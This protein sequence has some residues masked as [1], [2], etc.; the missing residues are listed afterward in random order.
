MS[1][2]GGKIILINS[3]IYKVSVI[4]PIYNAEKY[5]FD[6]LSSIANQEYHD[7][8][9]L[10][11]DDGSTDGSKE[12]ASIFLTNDRRFKYFHQQNRGVSA[13]RNYGI[14]NSSGE[15]IIFVDSDDICDSSYL[16]SLINAIDNQY[17]FVA[18]GYIYSEEKTKTFEHRI[19]SRVGE[20]SKKEC[21]NSI[22][23]DYSIYTFPWNK[24]YNK[25]IIN[26]FQIFFD[27]TITYGE[28]LLFN[29]NYSKNCHSFLFIES[30]GYTYQSHDGNVTGNFSDKGLESRLTFLT[31]IEKGEGLLTSRFQNEINLLRIKYNNVGLS[32]YRYM[33]KLNFT[34]DQKYI[35]KNKLRENYKY[36]YSK[37]TLKEKVKYLSCLL[38][39][40]VTS[41]ISDKYYSQK[42]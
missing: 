18:G 26:E 39:P 38:F 11:I 21:I 29:L 23:S 10:L 15:Y 1:Y 37:L 27:E 35:L 17:D 30:C 16:T 5:L 31:A 20:I 24:I 32:L 9:V 40:N 19:P 8:E 4:V 13:A 33:A 34:K 42:N 3:N 2:H 12:V 22:I 6:C 14:K 7:F 25:N 36:I 28:D 41:F